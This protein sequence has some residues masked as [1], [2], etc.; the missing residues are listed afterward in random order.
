MENA[1]VKRWNVV[2]YKKAVLIGCCHTVRH[3]EKRTARGVKLMKVTKRQVVSIC[4]L[5]ALAVLLCDAIG[6]SLHQKASPGG[7]PQLFYEGRYYTAP[8][9]GYKGLSEG[10]E[11]CGVVTERIADSKR[12]KRNGQC[13]W[14]EVGTAIYANPAEPDALY[15][16]CERP[17]YYYYFTVSE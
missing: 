5:L 9:D 2:T 7:Y 13:N 3:K 14:V 12:P 8:F 15:V 16:Q 10:W 1:F 4:A 6:N 11:Q 17:Q